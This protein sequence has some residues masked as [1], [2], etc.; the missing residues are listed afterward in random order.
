MDQNT[1][2]SA[3]PEKVTPADIAAEIASEWYFTARD[4]VLGELSSD[5]VPPTPFEKQNLPQT[6]GLITIC[7]LVLKN[8]IKVLGHS[9]CVRPEIFDA[10]LGRKYAREAAIKDVWPLLGFRLADQ[11]LAAGER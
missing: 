7:V 8:G 3:L 9:S 1:E 6:L 10:E 11:L 4:G 5:G 2:Q